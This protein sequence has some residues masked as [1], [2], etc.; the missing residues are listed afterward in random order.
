MKLKQ[1]IKLLQKINP[2][3]EISPGNIHYYIEHKNDKYTLDIDGDNFLIIKDETKR[4]LKEI[5]KVVIWQS[6]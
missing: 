5:K 3:A 6:E 4:N 2:N 1:F